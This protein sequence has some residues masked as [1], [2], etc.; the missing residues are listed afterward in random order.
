MNNAMMHDIGSWLGHAPGIAQTSVTA[1]GSGDATEINGKVFD[2]QAQRNRFLSVAAIVQVQ[3][4]LASGESI[5]IAGN[6][7][8]SPNNSDWTDFGD[9]QAATAVI[10]ATGGA[11]TAKAATVMFSADMVKA[12][13]Y[14]RLQTT[15]DMSRAGTDTALINAVLVFGGAEELPTG[16]VSS[17]EP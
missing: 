7:Q 14:I 15:P 12:A 11:V 10:T 3:A 4:T 17:R 6:F 8:S 16:A 9:A 5:T 13:R 1:G 2:R